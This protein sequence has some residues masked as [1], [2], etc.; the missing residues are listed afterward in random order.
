MPGKLPSP[1]SH[2]FDKAFDEALQ[3]GAD[4]NNLEPDHEYTVTFSVTVKWV[5]NP[6]WVVDKYNV[7][8]G[9]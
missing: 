7:D 6:G 2:A 8:L 5:D 4:Q 9:G 1:H 3:Q